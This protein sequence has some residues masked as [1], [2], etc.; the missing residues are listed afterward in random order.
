MEKPC[1][2]ATIEMRDGTFLLAWGDHVAS[3]NQITQEFK[4]I[5]NKSP[6]KRNIRGRN[7][8]FIC[9]Q[10]KDGRIIL[11]IE[12]RMVLFDDKY[13]R[14]HR[15]DIDV[16]VVVE[17]APGKVFC[18][19]HD[20][21]Y[22]VDLC[23]NEVREQS[24]DT[25]GTVMSMILL[26]GGFLM[27]GTSEGIFIRNKQYKIVLQQKV[28]GRHMRTENRNTFSEIT[29]NII[30]YLARQTAHTYNAITGEY[31]QYTF[32]EKVLSFVCD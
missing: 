15:F 13:N 19:A 30:G 10:L 16:D 27:I 6:R 14:L 7:V 5:L 17:I 3:Y 29:P 1:C 25:F 12:E 24:V 31:K 21:F 9:Y 4:F 22:C 28:D 23:T 2:C 32:K 26:A 8:G 11:G 18:S 20:S